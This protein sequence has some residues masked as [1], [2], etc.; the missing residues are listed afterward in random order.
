MTSSKPQ[1]LPHFWGGGFELQ[2]S[3]IVT[4]D[5]DFSGSYSATNLNDP[6]ND[7]DVANKEYIDM[8]LKGIDANMKTTVLLNNVGL[9]NATKLDMLPVTGAC[10]LLVASQV[11]NGPVARFNLFASLPSR[12]DIAKNGQSGGD[13]QKGGYVRLALYKDTAN[14]GAYYLYKLCDEQGDENTYDGSYTIVA[15]CAN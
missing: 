5:I 2:N 7:K 10:T 4:S 9:S 3:T 12:G 15:T 1:R 13:G 6:I 8:L 14:D 11:V